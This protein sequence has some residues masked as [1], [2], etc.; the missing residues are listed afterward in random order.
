MIHLN[1]KY[2][3]VQKFSILKRFCDFYEIQMVYIKKIKLVKVLLTF[4]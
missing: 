2:T 4:W 3:E 1:V